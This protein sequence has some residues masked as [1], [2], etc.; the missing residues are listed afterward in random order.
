MFSTIIT[1]AY[2]KNGTK[3]KYAESVGIFCIFIVN[4]K[5]RFENCGVSAN[6]YLF[7]L[8]KT[9]IKIGICNVWLVFPGMKLR[10]EY[11]TDI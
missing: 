9:T 1:H 8:R 10:K 5:V 2:K 11:L 7:S 3:N 6:F 4:M